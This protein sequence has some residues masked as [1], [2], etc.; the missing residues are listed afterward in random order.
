MCEATDQSGDKFFGVLAKNGQADG[1]WRVTGGTG[2]YQGMD[3]SG[4]F[5]T[6]NEKPSIP[7]QAGGV[8]HWWGN[9]KMR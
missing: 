5:N 6:A 9:Y 1:T 8:F 4:A 3:H 7:G 2:K